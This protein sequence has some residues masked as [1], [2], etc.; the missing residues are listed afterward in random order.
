MPIGFG[1]VSGSNSFGRRGA[2]A[3]LSSGLF[4]F[5]N[6]TFL[7]IVSLGSTT[8]PTLGQ[9]QSAYAGTPWISSYFGLGSYQ[10]YQRW[11]VPKT[12]TYTIEAGG[13]AGGGGSGSSTSQCYGAK[14]IGNFS[15]T[16]G[17]ILEMVIGVAGGNNGG[18]H[19]NENGGGGGTFIK[20]ITTGALMIVAGGSGG[21]ASTT[22]ASGCP[23]YVTDQQGQSGN[24]GGYPSVCASY[25]GYYPGT[26]SSGY[27]GNAA[28]SYYGGAGGGYYSAG[29]NGLTHC[30]T[31]YGGGYYG[32]GLVGGTGNVC[33]TYNNTGGFGGGGG[34]QLGG[35]GGGGGY[36]GGTV[37]GVWASYGHSGGGGSYNAGS[38]QTNTAGGN[39]G[40]T[41][42]YCKI[43]QL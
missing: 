41:A 8:G 31:A 36:T 6:Y 3:I 11:T 40:S 26:P 2:P 30:A 29:A 5:T 24:S 33:Y 14:I 23:Q 16:S 21:S 27:G 20:N 7:P 13:A 39:S 42:G 19:G 43:T 18:A 34:G 38:S 22:Y 15:L 1:S 9:M 32:N 17:D 10:G 35:P 12:G 28:G 4:A 37:I 25:S